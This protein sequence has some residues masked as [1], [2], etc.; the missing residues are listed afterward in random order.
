MFNMCQHNLIC[1]CSEQLYK[2]ITFYLLL[3]SNTVNNMYSS[4]VHIIDMRLLGKFQPTAQLL[5]EAILDYEF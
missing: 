4:I 3:T 2:F 1:E 5:G